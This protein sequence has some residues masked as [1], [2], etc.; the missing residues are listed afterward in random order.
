MGKILEDAYKLLEKMA[1]NNYQWPSERMTLRKAIRILEIDVLSSLATQ[2]ANLTKKIDNLCVN[3]VQST[4]LVC[5]FCAINHTSVE[6]QVGNPFT[7]T[8]TLEQANFVSNY[9]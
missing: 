5:E 1:A 6:C 8:T 4:N 2:L 7:T 3:S 9:Q